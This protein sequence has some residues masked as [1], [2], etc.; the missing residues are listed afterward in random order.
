[1]EL[2]DTPYNHKSAK[3]NGNTQCRNNF[4]GDPLPGIRKQCYCD[5]DNWY[6]K[7]EM[8]IDLAQF[9]AK[10]AEEEALQQQLIAEANR[11]AAEE[12]SIRIQAEALAA[13]A[14]S[15]AEALARETAARAAEEAARAKASAEATAARD[16][17]HA[18]MMAAQNAAQKAELEAS[19]AEH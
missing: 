9:A 8:D 4:F 6:P 15:E 14:A 2:V 13:V 10:K 12:E 7:A 18:A 11:K 5:A 17:G 19:Q 1:M 3:N 16:A